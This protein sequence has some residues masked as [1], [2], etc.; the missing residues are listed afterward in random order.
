MK[1]SS[2]DAARDAGTVDYHIDD[3]NRR[4]PEAG[5]GKTYQAAHI[6][7]LSQFFDMARFYQNHLPAAT[8]QGSWGQAPHATYRGMEHPP[9]D[10]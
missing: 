8:A 4:L 3:D 1:P 10:E 9:C 7:S 6:I 2:A 5:D